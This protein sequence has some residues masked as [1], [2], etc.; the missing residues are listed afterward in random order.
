MSAFWNTERLVNTTTTGNQWGASNAI[1]TD[2]GSVVVWTDLSTSPATIRLR[3]FDVFGNPTTLELG[4]GTYSADTLSDGQ[5]VKVTALANGGYAVGWLDTTGTLRV[6]KYTATDALDGFT[7]TLTLQGL[8]TTNSFSM[9]GLPGGN[10]AVAYTKTIAGERDVAMKINTAGTSTFGAEIVVDGTAGSIQQSPS[11]S[12]DSSFF[13]V[14]YGNSVAGSD[15][16]KYS[17]SGGIVRQADLLPNTGNTVA[18]AVNNDQ[19]TINLSFAGDIIVAYGASIFYDPLF[20]VNIGRANTSIKPAIVALADSSFFITYVNLNG[21]LV[22]QHITEL[23][24]PVEA[25][26]VMTTGGFGSVSSLSTTVTTDGRVAV[27]WAQTGGTRPDSTGF[28][29]YTRIIDPRNGVVTGT[30]GGETLYGNQT[31]ADQISGYG[32]ND[33]LFGLGGDDTLYG[34]D[35][36]DTLFGGAGNDFLFGD[37]GADTAVYSGARANYTITRAGGTVT[38]TDNRAGSPDGTDMLN[39]VEFVRFNTPNIT[40]LT[41]KQDVNG[42]GTSDVLLRNGAGVIA[43]FIIGNGVI[44][45]SASVANTPGYTVAGTGDF[46]GDGTADMLLLNGAGVVVN[47]TFGNGAITGTNT[48]GGTSG[49]SVVGTG[50]FNG[51]GTSDVLLQNGAGV[52][53]T[54]I[55]GNGVI[56]G[57]GGIANLPGFTVVATGDFNG[58]G[59]ADILAQNAAGAVMNLTMGNGATTGSSM[60]GNLGG[61]TIAGTGDFNADGTADVLLQNGSGIFAEWLMGN[62]VITGGGSIANV[63]GYTVASIGDYSGVSGVADGTSDILLTNAAGNIQNLVMQNGVSIN[64]Y[65]LGTVPGFTIQP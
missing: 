21:L 2:G 34:G 17:F 60:I 15:A 22:G 44:A 63:P 35:G 12:T 42:D 52:I 45:S 64:L 16:K 39:G 54:W 28:G 40:S 3:R 24:A 19:T 58:D 47:V 6:Q 8:T 41:V 51:D 56:T 37:L 46:N 5:A 7:Q 20:T 13:Y 36:A 27:T 25:P 31:A 23:G 9:L 48:V 4:L 38:I 50:D 61:L 32:G 11:L 30:E 33:T 49:L 43:T 55:I 18:V 57:G 59:T 65:S 29:T 10:L 14:S 53:A 62:G 26:L 1:L